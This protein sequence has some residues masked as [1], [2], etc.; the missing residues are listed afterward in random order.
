MSLARQLLKVVGAAGDDLPLAVDLDGVND[1]LTRT[2]DFTGNSDSKQFFIAGSFYNI[3]ATNDQIYSNDALAPTGATGFELSTATNFA[4]IARNSAGTI[5]LNAQVSKSLKTFNTYVISGD[6]STPGSLRIYINDEDTGVTPSTFTNDFIAFSKSGHWF[7]GQPAFGYQFFG[8]ISPTYFG[9]FHIDFDVESN[10]RLLTEISSTE[11]FIILSPE[12]VIANLSGNSTP[13]FWTAMT[14]PEDLTENLGTSA[15]LW[16]VN[17]V[18]ARSNRGPNQYNAVASNFDGTADNLSLAHAIPNGKQFTASFIIA[19]RNAGFNVYPLSFGGAGVESVECS[20]STT[21]FNF[22]FINSAS[23]RVVKA[24]PTAAN[25]N[26]GSVRNSIHQFDISFDTSDVGKRHLFIDGFLAPDTVWT[27]YVIDSIIEY[28]DTIYIGRDPNGGFPAGPSDYGHVFFDDSYVSMPTESSF[29]DYGLN[30]PKYIGET[31]EL[32]TGSQPRVYLPVRGDMAGEN[33][34]SLG[35][36]TVGSGPFT[37]ARGLSE[38]WARSAFFDGSTDY[39]SNTTAWPASSTKTLSMVFAVNFTDVSTVINVRTQ[40]KD[41]SFIIR[42]N[43]AGGFDQFRAW[44]TAGSEIMQMGSTAL[45]DDGAWGVVHLCIDMADQSKTKVFSGG[46]DVTAAFAIFTDDF[47]NTNIHTTYIGAQWSG[48]SP[49]NEYTGDLAFVYLTT[50]YIDFTL[51]E[52]RLLF[53]DGLG[54]PVPLQQSIDDGLIPEGLI[55]M[56]FE[57]TTD[58]GANSGISGDFTINGAVTPGADVNG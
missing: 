37:G 45:P 3:N 54:N 43:A 47:I 52:T 50:D 2:S 1:Y 38:F 53:V 32:V 25:T 48:G 57:D 24:S 34:G 17:G 39:L 44:N 19:G 35:N 8:R 12:I 21:T 31:G 13:A 40:E 55:R 4:I 18:M 26:W 11:G 30:K 16:A 29:W 5:I 10:R 41:F 42:F 28:G 51:E 46:F 20:G 22:D 56:G 6:M 9:H 14:N 36:F 58:L 33:L 23:A 27:D 7:G 15:D 49:V